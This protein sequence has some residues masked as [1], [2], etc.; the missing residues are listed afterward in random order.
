MVTVFA[1]IYALLDALI[2]N[3]LALRLDKRMEMKL[4][5]FDV[6]ISFAISI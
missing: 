3:L 2:S 4:S 1:Q 5:S 6:L